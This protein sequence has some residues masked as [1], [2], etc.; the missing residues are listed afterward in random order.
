MNV[1]VKKTINKNVIAKKPLTNLYEMNSSFVCWRVKPYLRQVTE[2]Q[3]GEIMRLWLYKKYA[4]HNNI[5]AQART[6]LF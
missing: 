6:M 2:K 4:L 5:N 1:S 3:M